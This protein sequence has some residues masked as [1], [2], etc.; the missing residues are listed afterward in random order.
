V[1]FVKAFGAFCYEFIVGDDWKIAAAVVA[2]L[3]ILAVATVGAWFSDTGLAI[4]GG[5]LIVIGFTTSVL[6]DVRT[7]D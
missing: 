7:R 5:A 1:R 4:F 3:A 6:I 2:A